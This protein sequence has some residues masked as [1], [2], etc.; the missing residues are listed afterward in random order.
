MTLRVEWAIACRYAEVNNNL[1]TIV[2]AGIDH[3]YVPALPMNVQ[4]VLAVRLVGDP[5]EATSETHT[6]RCVAF[7]PDTLDE[8]ARAEGELDMRGS[9]VLSS[10]W[11][12]SIHVPMGVMFHA[13]S[14]GAYRLEVSVD[15]SDAYLLPMHISSAPLPGA[16]PPPAT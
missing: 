12:A 11:L 8:L 9:A 10:D 4:V 6:L 2:G 3:M 16:P 13:E 15:D 7:G 14:E 5:E 1:A